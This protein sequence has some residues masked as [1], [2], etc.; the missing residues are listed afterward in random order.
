MDNKAFFKMSYGLYLISSKSK[1]NAGGCVVNT[2]IQVTSNPLQMTVTINKDNYTTSLIQ[3][4][5]YFTGVALAESATMDLIGEFGFKSSKDTDKFAGFET[6]TDENGIPYV[7]EQ[8]V[9][10][11]S[12][13]VKET[14]DVGTHIIFLGEVTN[15]EV[16]DTEDAMTYTYYHKVKNG[17]T[18]PKASSYIAEE[19]KGYRCK[20][21]G[22]VLEADVVPDDFECPICGQGKDQMVKL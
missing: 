18:P 22:Y 15:A 12:C 10:R 14:M 13:K 5:R 2:L 4:S 17:V 3:E 8:T 16:L 9:A 20:I 21:C 1:E 19:K 7:G 11:F 6:R